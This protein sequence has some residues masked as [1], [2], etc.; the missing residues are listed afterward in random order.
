MGTVIMFAVGG[1]GLLYLLG[2]AKATAAANPN[3]GTAGVLSQVNNIIKTLTKQPTATQPQQ[4]PASGG[5]PAGGGGGSGNASG[6]KSASPNAGNVT[7]PSYLSD[8]TSAT[9]ALKASGW[10]DSDIQ[11]AKDATG[12]DASTIAA[13][14][15]IGVTQDQMTEPGQSVFSDLSEGT[16]TPDQQQ[17]AA[18]QWALNDS[19]SQEIAAGATSDQQFGGGGGSDYTYESDNWGTGW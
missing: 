5:S 19:A 16:S 6:T 7:I 9:N 8:N 15:E 14:S 12:Y 1:I 2:K 3:V 18:A 4:K 17:A 10:T 13:L 11:A